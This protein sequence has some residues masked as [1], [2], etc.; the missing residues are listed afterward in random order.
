MVDIKKRDL[1]AYLLL[2]KKIEEISSI[3]VWLTRNGLE[4][5]IAVVKNANLV[6]ITQCLSQ[7]WRRVVSKLRLNGSKVVI[8]PSEGYAAKLENRKHFATGGAVDYNSCID[9]LYCWNQEMYDYSLNL[10]KVSKSILKVSGIP[11]FDLYESKFKDFRLGMNQIKKRQK[12][13]LLF[14][15]NFTQA[16][17]Y[18]YDTMDSYKSLMKGFGYGHSNAEEYDEFLDN[19]AFEESKSRD[20][21]VEFIKKINKKYDVDIVIKPHPGEKL[22]FWTDRFTKS[23]FSNIEI[24]IN[25]YIWGSIENA[26][27]ILARSCTTQIESFLLEKCSAEVVLNPND[28]HAERGSIGNFM[29]TNIGDFDKLF[30]NFK[31]NTWKTKQLVLERKAI[32]NNWGI[33]PFGNDSINTVAKDLIELSD[34]KANSNLPYFDKVKNYI[35]Y[36]FFSSFDFFFHNLL[37]QKNKRRLLIKNKTFI[38]YLGRVDKHFHLK[39]IDFLNSILNKKL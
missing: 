18:Y 19:F 8:L 36:Y 15:S 1:P 6:V 27:I 25:D 9:R 26:D 31:S 20:L 16:D 12:I 24:S 38:D 28:M 2:K 35:K 39:D 33:K 34:F 5:P 7:E 11:R 29:V 32:L 22:E 13:S 23:E 14:V 3:N 21:C 30:T 4:L 10:G 37:I 17:H